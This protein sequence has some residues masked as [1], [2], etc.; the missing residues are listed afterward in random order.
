MVKNRQVL[1]AL[2]LGSL[3]IIEVGLLT[4]W[5]GDMGIYVQPII[6]LLL[7]ALFAVVICVSCV[8]NLH[9]SLPTISPMNA[10]WT[11]VLTAILFMALSL[12]NGRLLVGIVEAFP[13]DPLS[14]DIIPALQLYVDRVMSFSWVYAPMEFQGWTV[15]PSYLPMMY[16]PYIIPECLHMDYRYWPFILFTVITCWQ[17]YLFIKDENSRLWQAG[18]CLLPVLLLHIFLANDQAVFGHTT[19][20]MIAVYYMLLSLT[21]LNPNV[22]IAGLGIIP[23]LLSR[24]SLTLWLPYYALIYYLYYGWPKTVKVIGVVLLA[25][26]ALYVLPFMTQDPFV[27]FKGVKYYDQSTLGE[28]RPHAWQSDGE[29]PYHLGRGIGFAV[30]AYTGMEAEL[31]DKVN[32]MKLINVATAALTFLLMLAFYFLMKKRIKHMKLFLIGMLKVYLMIFYSFIYMPYLYLYITPLLLGASILY[33][34]SRIQRT[35]IAN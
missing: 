13:I 20:L 30:Y 3:S 32:R 14:S 9:S 12:D 26:C 19:E 29:I 18:I 1:I 11:K 23:A 35:G 17:L 8:S 21:V 7:A 31:I 22:W 16:L 34:M 6:Y 27:F 25:V 15:I 28:W 10:L 33:E 5:L 2:V 24:Y 4:W